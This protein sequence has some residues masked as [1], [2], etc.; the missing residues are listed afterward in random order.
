MQATRNNT[1]EFLTTTRQLTNKERLWQWER[2]KQA[3]KDV[4]KDDQNYLGVFLA[5]TIL[6]GL[7]A[8]MLGVVIEP[9]GCVWLWNHEGINKWCGE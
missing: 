7:A 2:R 8:V 3:R 4:Q 6:G 9:D 1:P 5:I